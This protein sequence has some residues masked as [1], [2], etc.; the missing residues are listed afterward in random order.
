MRFFI[1][2]KLI[3]FYLYRNNS[4]KILNNIIL[5]LMKSYYIILKK[6]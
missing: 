6:E 3:I 2:M 1:I 5:K 4:V